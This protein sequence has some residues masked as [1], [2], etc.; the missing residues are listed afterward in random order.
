MSLADLLKRGRFAH[1]RSAAETPDD[2]TDESVEEERIED[3]EEDKKARRAKKAKKADD[4]PSDLDGEDLDDEETD[5]EDDDDAGGKKSKK[6]K[7]AKADDDGDDDY[8]AED[9]GD[10]EK[11]IRADERARCSAIFAT[12][13]AAKLPDLAASLAFGTDLPARDAVATLERTALSAK[14]SLASRMAVQPIPNPGTDGG[15]AP[16]PSSPKSLAAA[17]ISAARKARGE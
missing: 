1:L 4:A 13:A 7:K 11:A 10:K 5:E 15:Q 12:P 6:A 16:D 2:K 9:E 17:A 14:S 3:E 8:D